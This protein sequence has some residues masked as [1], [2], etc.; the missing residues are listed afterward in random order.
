DVKDTNYVIAD[1]NGI[2]ITGATITKSWELDHVKIAGQITVGYDKSQDNGI[3]I[4]TF[5]FSGDVT[6]ST[7]AEPGKT[8]TLNNVGAGINA[9]IKNGVLTNFGFDVTGSFSFH[10]LTVSV[11]GGSSQKFSFQYDT[12]LKQ[13]E[14]GGGLQLEFHGNTLTADFGQQTA[15]GI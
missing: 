1:H 7:E 14:L 11:L 12:N 5:Y 2:T 3:T 6:V 8:A 13:F 10:G 4:N 15:P 9:T